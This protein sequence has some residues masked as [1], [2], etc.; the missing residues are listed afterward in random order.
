MNKV[1]KIVPAPLPSPAKDGVGA[2]PLAVASV[3]PSGAAAS[4]FTLTR[5]LELGRELEKARGEALQVEITL[6]IVRL[7]L[8]LGLEADAHNPLLEAK[9][10][11]EANLEELGFADRAADSAAAYADYINDCRRNDGE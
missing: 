8:G 11:L 5:W 6:D 3:S 9:G 7:M 10:L 4:P 1:S 2:T